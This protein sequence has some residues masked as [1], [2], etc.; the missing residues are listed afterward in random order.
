M[1]MPFSDN[2]SVEIPNKDSW[3]EI[4]RRSRIGCITDTN[5]LVWV[6]L[7]QL[8]PHLTFHSSALAIHALWRSLALTLIIRCDPRKTYTH[9]LRHT[10]KQ[11]KD[12]NHWIIWIA[13]PRISEYREWNFKIRF[14][15][16]ESNP[17]TES[18]L[19]RCSSDVSASDVVLRTQQLS[20]EWRVKWLTF[21]HFGIYGEA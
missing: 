2:T 9:R 1:Q 10:T 20:E 21:K 4:V 11:L 13:K 6:E 15:I 8:V 7:V 3:L 19:I 16:S 12:K 17:G 5:S 18:K 14:S